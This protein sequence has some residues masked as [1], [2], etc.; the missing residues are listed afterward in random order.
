[1]R[2]LYVK[3]SRESVGVSAPLPVVLRTNGKPSARMAAKA[4]ASSKGRRCVC[5]PIAAHESSVVGLVV[6][7]ERVAV[8]VLVTGHV[9]P[10][11][12]DVG[13]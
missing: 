3:V 11:D 13:W 7:D 9:P 1:M 6:Y 12:N 10:S 2:Y 4:P 5:T 8:R